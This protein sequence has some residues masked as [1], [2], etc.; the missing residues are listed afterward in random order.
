MD[1]YRLACRLA[2]RVPTMARTAAAATVPAGRPPSTADTL[3]RRQREVDQL[4]TP[5][6]GSRRRRRLF[7][8]VASK[9]RAFNPV[10]LS[11]DTHRGIVTH[12]RQRRDKTS[13]LVATEFVGPPVS[14]NSDTDYD[15]GAD[16]GAYRASY[17]YLQSGALN[18]YRG[19]LDCALTSATWTSTYVLGYQ[20]DR[21]NGTVS[22]FDRWQLD[23]G[24]EVGSVRRSGPGGAAA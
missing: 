16:T 1:R 5:G 12:V 6:S 4:A 21:P 2:A 13:A 22:V 23:A 24:A 17:A 11:G 8:E 3:W 19:Y 9:R 18:A 14:S 7:V 15:R 10:V 20:V